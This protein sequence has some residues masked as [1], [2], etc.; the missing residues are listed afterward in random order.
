MGLIRGL[1]KRTGQAMGV[2]VRD[3]RHTAPAILGTLLRRLQ[4]V[5]VL[6]IGANIGQYA[7]EVRKAGYGGLIV[8]FEAQPDLCR[9]LLA[10]ARADRLWRIAPAAALGARAGSVELNLAGNSA[11]SSVLDMLPAHLRAAPQSAYVGRQRVPLARLDELSVPLLPPDGKLFVKVDTQ[12]YER[13]V[14]TGAAG[15]LPRVDAMQIEL[16]LRTLYAGAPTMLEMLALLSSLGFDPFHLVP[17][18]D[19]AGSG[20]LLQAEGFFVRRELLE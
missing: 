8:S 3:L 15:V 16:S 2:D 9:Q 4:P 5:A 7:R 10:D 13:E 17:A 19:D 1:V 11:S 14:L 12:G 18:F 6:D 20:R